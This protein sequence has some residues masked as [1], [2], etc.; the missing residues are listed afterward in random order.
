MLVDGFQISADSPVYL[1]AEMSANH[2][3]SIENAFKT[4]DAA[5]LAGANAIK[6]Q[7]YTPDTLT[8]KSKRPEFYLNGGFGWAAFVRFVPRRHTLRLAC[9]VIRRKTTWHHHFNPIR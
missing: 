4:I 6:L 2:N 3:G 7:T 9:V 5:K 1:I 8:I